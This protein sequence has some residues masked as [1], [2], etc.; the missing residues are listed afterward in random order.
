MTPEQV[1]TAVKEV[2]SQ[3][4]MLH[5]FIL[6]IVVAAG[7]YLGSY[8]REKGKNLATKEDIKTVTR[9]IESIRSDYKKEEYRYQLTAAGL[10]KK[11]AEVIKKLYQMIVDIEEAYNRVV[12][13]MEW[14]GEPSNDELRKQAGEL[15]Y[16]FLR[17]YKQDRIF[18]SDGL[19]TKL[20][21]F[22]DLIYKEF[23][24]YS[25][26]LTAK[27]R[28]DVLKDFTDTWVKANEAFKTKIPLARQAIEEEFRALLGVN[29]A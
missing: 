20:Q 29:D 5:Y 18:F 26:A 14:P 24:P 4:A 7:A 11:R 19:C 25:I 9:T 8:L 12:D 28:G 10:L 1:E 13:Y 16:T 2:F 3:S 17:Q 27:L 21:G 22:V 15:L 23:M 6:L